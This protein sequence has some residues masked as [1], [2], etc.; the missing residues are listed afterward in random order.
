LKRITSKSEIQTIR[1]L[2]R[3]VKCRVRQVIRRCRRNIQAWGMIDYTLHHIQKQAV[4]MRFTYCTLYTM[5]AV[6]WL[7]LS[8]PTRSKEKQRN[9]T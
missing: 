3:H 6:R 5:D 9:I 8:M 1:I 7:Q 4:H 2:T